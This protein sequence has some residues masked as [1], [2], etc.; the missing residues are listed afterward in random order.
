MTTQ[1]KDGL[2]PAAVETVAGLS[3][4]L[5]S[6]IIVHPLDIIKTRLQGIFFSDHCARC[7]Y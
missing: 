7:E 4:G 5:I 6:T 3:A 1:K 2:S